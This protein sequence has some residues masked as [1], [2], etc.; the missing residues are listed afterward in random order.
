MKAEKPQVMTRE[1]TQD[2]DFSDLN[3][4]LSIDAISGHNLGQP[5]FS[6]SLG[7]PPET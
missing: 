3:W 1:G 5:L 4:S 6:L 7:S 2:R